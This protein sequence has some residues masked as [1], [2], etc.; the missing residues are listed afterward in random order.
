M[1][2]GFDVLSISEIVS[3]H[4]RVSLAHV[5]AIVAQV[6]PNDTLVVLVSVVEG[7]AVLVMAM[8]AIVFVLR[9]HP[10]CNVVIPVTEVVLHLLLLPQHLLCERVH[11]C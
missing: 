10:S 6:S 4:V 9:S 8:L 11:V 2:V 7:F 5:V 1:V 3:S